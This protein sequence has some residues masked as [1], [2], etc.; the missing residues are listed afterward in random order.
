MRGKSPH[1]ALSQKERVIRPNL[2]PRANTRFAPRRKG[3]LGNQEGGET[4]PLREWG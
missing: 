1:P 3:G 2:D 4:P